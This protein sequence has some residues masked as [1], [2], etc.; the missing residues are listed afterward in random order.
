MSVEHQP[1]RASDRDRDEVLVRLHTAY[2]EGRLSET[3]LDERIDLTLAART[4]D[5]L[6]RV[7]ADLP[8]PAA[9]GTPAGR[10]QVAY[11]DTVTRA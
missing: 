8:R 10:L 6:G 3:E 9:P 4:H 7:S 5:D 2:A 1:L 11:K